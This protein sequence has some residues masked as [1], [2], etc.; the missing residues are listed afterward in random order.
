MRVQMRLFRH[1]AHALLVS[2]RIALN[3]LAIEQ[4]LARSHLDESRYHFHGGGLAGA[5]RPQ[6]TGHLAG[7]RLKADV[8]DGNGAGESF[9]NVAKLEHRRPCSFRPTILC[10]ILLS[11]RLGAGSER[12]PISVDPC[13]SA[14]L[15]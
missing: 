11:C 2:D 9:R 4:D 13:A 1:V 10:S 14:A 3:A 6:V 5:V 7:A 12:F 15:I 8:V